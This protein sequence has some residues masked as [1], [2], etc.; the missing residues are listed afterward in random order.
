MND[1]VIII[2]SK[3]LE[4]YSE[5]HIAEN[6]PA[7]RHFIFGNFDFAWPFCDVEG[8]TAHGLSANPRKRAVWKIQ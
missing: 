4:T 7:G 8:S 6:G 5:A 2:A 1:N 3:Q